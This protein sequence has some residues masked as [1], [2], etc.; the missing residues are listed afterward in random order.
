MV[1]NKIPVKSLECKWSVKVKFTDA[2]QSKKI[3]LMASLNTPTFDHIAVVGAEA[4]GTCHR[5]QIVGNDFLASN[6][7]FIWEAADLGAAN[8]VLLIPKQR[9]RQSE[10]L[11]AWKVAQDLGFS[12]IFPAREYPITYTMCAIQNSIIGISQFGGLSLYSSLIPT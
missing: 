11:Q 4:V 3:E 1:Q 8:S 12:A 7:K 9:G 10:T 5:L 2:E 6:S